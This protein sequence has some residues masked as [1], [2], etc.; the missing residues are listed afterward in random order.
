MYY[1]LGLLHRVTL[2]IAKSRIRIPNC[3]CHSH[4]E[5][6]CGSSS[7]L[8]SFE[9]N[10]RFCDQQELQQALLWFAFRSTTLRG[11]EKYTEIVIQYMSTRTC[12]W[13]LSR[14]TGKHDQRLTCPMAS[15]YK[16]GT[17]S[18]VI[19]STPKSSESGKL[20]V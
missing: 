2:F 16:W 12:N 8:I 17:P 1:C 9:L 11:C 20:I 18:G 5:H 14:E 15:L 7:R 6:R 13:I 10:S 19:S 4:W 3:A